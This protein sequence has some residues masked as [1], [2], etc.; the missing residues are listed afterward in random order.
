MSMKIGPDCEGSLHDGHRIRRSRFGYCGDLG[1][2]AHIARN[3]TSAPA[4]N[5]VTYFAPPGAALKI[6]ADNPGNCPF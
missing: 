3:E 2:H 5:V 6:D 1:E 4:Q